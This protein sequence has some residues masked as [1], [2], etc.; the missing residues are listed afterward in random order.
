MRKEAINCFILSLKKSNLT[1]HIQSM[2]FTAA[3]ELLIVNFV[4]SNGNHMQGDSLD[5]G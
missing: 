3:K 2:H 1:L 4:K 5:Q